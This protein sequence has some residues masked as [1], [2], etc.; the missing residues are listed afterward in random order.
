MK[1]TDTNQMRAAAENLKLPWSTEEEIAAANEIDDLRDQ[2]S[3][4]SK[5]LSNGRDYLMQIDPDKI[6][7]EDSLIAFGWDSNGYAIR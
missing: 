6:T 5:L 4:M 7:V 3:E 1:K 2:V